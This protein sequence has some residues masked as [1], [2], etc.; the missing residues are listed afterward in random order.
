MKVLESNMNFKE[1]LKYEYKQAIEQQKQIEDVVKDAMNNF[2]EADKLGSPD[3]NSDQSSGLSSL[4]DVVNAL[5]N[6]ETTQE[7]VQEVT[8]EELFDSYKQA[9]QNDELLASSS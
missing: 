3:Q 2:N 5:D 6:K 9:Q 8:Q 7:A 1:Q 4:S